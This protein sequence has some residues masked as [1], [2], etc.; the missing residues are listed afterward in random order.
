MTEVLEH[1]A[2]TM[3]GLAGIL[4]LLRVGR[5]GSLPDKVLGA[6]TLIL[7]VAAG[8]A[9]GAGVTRNA[10]FLD[11]LVVVTM[12]SF[13]GTITVARYVERRGARA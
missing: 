9:A 5:G 12:L 1:A 2:L 7:V 3:L 6:D 8:V 10:S 11:S 4:A 13:V